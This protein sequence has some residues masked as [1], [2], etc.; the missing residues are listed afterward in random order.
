[1]RKFH[2]S[3]CLLLVLCYAG[4]AHAQDCDPYLPCGPL[5]WQLPSLP[6]LQSPTPFPTIVSVATGSTS[7]PTASP[8]NTGT[9]LP[10]S[11]PM[12]TFTPFPTFTLYPTFTALPTWTP[13]IDTSDL[14][15]TVGT[16][17]AMVD[18]TAIPIDLN[19]TPVNMDTVTDLADNTTS[20]FGYARGLSEVNFGALTP[21]VTFMFISFVIF[22]FVKTILFLLPLFAAL[23][24]VIRKIVELVLDFIPG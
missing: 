17:N 13:F 4:I 8:T 23:F 2:I 18:A 3:L 12:A 16:L 22:V 10:T 6:D 14:N 7:T 21:L 19:G 11:T 24:G 9:A 15:N 20:I 5:P 1:M